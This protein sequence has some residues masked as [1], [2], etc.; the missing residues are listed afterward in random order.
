M[1]VA[2]S[3]MI[4]FLLFSNIS[5][6]EIT[7][8]QC[9]YINKAD[10]I[11]KALTLMAPSVYTGSAFT[12]TTIIKNVTADEC[13]TAKANASN[14]SL[15]VQYR[16]DENSQWQNTGFTVDGGVQNTIYAPTQGLNPDQETGFADDF[17]FADPGQYR[18][19]GM[20]DGKT[21]VDER[22]EYNNEN[23]TNGNVD[24]Q[25]SITN[26]N[27]GYVIVLPAKDYVPSKRIKS[28]Q[29]PLVQYIGHKLLY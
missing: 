27:I 4:C 8:E 15:E 3:L 7:E 26:E 1:K 20:A 24:G 5:C 23:N 12:L 21:E 17:I 6:N 28:G 29:L 25:K 18:F 2:A 14:T 9:D 13:E 16:T 19:L 22:D 10:M 11:A